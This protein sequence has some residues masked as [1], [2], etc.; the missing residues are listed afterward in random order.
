MLNLNTINDKE[1]EKTIKSL[2]K[3]YRTIL[4]IVNNKL[5]LLDNEVYVT[6]RKHLSD[7]VEGLVP[8]E[9]KKD[10]QNFYDKVFVYY[11]D[12]EILHLL[13]N[14][15]KMV[16]CYPDN[17]G[18]YHKILDMLYFNSFDFD[19]EDVISIL[20]ISRSTYY[21]LLKKAHL[22]YYYHLV[23]ILKGENKEFSESKLVEK[24]C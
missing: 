4:H 15:C 24:F 8:F 20:E 14:I 3:L 12:L 19:S 7:I 9:T 11:T 2:L 1:K 22:C 13:E 5:V 23:A 16:K 10:E 18:T 21:R 6:S 17:G